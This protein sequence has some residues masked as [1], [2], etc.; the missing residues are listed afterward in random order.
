MNKVF[1]TPTHLYNTMDGNRKNEVIYAG[2]AVYDKLHGKWDRSS[3]TLQQV[4]TMEEKNR[5]NSTT[6]CRYLRDEAVEGEMAAVYSTHAERRD[7]HIKSDGQFWISKTKG[8][9]LR[10]EEDI[11]AGDGVKN[12]LSTRYEYANVQAP[13]L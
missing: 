12:H 5:Q 4:M 11:D 10:H 2:G 6:M 13:P 7:P 3:V 8:L 9:P 1:T